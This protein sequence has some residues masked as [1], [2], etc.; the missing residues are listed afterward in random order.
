MKAL[1]LTC[2]Q[3]S[4]SFYLVSLI[5]CARLFDRDSIEE[6][7][8]WVHAC[9]HRERF[10]KEY[11]LHAFPIVASLAAVQLNV[12]SLQR[13]LTQ[14]TAAKAQLQEDQK[15]NDLLPSELYRMI[16]DLQTEVTDL[17]S[18]VA[19][20]NR[21]VKE[22]ENVSYI[23]AVTKIVSLSAGLLWDDIRRTV[24]YRSV[25]VSGNHAGIRHHGPSHHSGVCYGES[26]LTTT[27]STIWTVR[28]EEIH[29]PTSNVFGV[30][31]AQ[32][33]GDRTVFTGWTTLI[34]PQMSPDVLEL[35]DWKTGDVA[36][37]IY[38]PSE[39]GFTLRIEK[40]DCS[41]ELHQ[42]VFSVSDLIA[43]EPQ[44]SFSRPRVSTAVNE[45]VSMQD[46]SIHIAARFGGAISTVSFLLP[47][48][49]EVTS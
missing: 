38:T 17:T 46:A 29:Q 7:E 40:G 26:P 42:R 18:Q 5:D 1:K 25:N 8:I 35:M 22:R 6:D 15:Y 3:P 13:E 27:R 47:D 4:F 30:G 23:M 43:T 31:V 39:E 34:S 36:S 19:T 24:S 9:R 16:V 48:L 45:V 44:N 41:R 37:F 21:R 11:L 49:S 20:C 33:L 10:E 32:K 12:S 2:G 28:V 14:M